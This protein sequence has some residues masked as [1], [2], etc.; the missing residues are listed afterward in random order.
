MAVKSYEEAGVSIRKGDDFASFIQSFPS[1]A[2][3]KGIGGFAGGLP[4]DV[5]G[6]REPMLLTCTD[7]VGT[8]LLVAKKLGRYD[9]IGVD[10][11]AMSVNDL[12]CCGAKPLQFLDY[13]ACG[14]ID[15]RVLHDVIKGVIDGCEQA[16]CTLTGGE[17]AEMP[18]VYAPDDIDL[19]GFAVGVVD[20]SRMLPRLDDMAEGDAIIGLASSGAHSN[21]YS[22]ARKAVRED[23]AAAWE[24]L[25]VPTRIYVKEA[26]ELI[27]TGKVL[28]AAHITGSGLIENFVRVIPKSLAPEFTWDWPLPEVFR[29]IMSGGVPL[30]EMRRVFNMG[31]GMT[32]VCKE[33]DCESLLA[34]ANG[35]GM[36]AF[37]AGRLVR[38]KG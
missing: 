13:L 3:S 6:M 21:G 32:F 2:V 28:A 17:T 15:E 7:G 34:L 35:R 14:S 25:L 27:G 24:R 29:D 23:D 31:V 5:A 18:D 1:K 8:K 33:A 9:T 36:G 30:D 10:L 38:A 19:A 12:V 26:L 22:L 4:L 20:R 11:V 16:G 37:R